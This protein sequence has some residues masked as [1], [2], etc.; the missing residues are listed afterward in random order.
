MESV[1]LTN[2]SDDDDDSNNREARSRPGKTRSHRTRARH[3]GPPGGHEASRARRVIAGRR[4]T[5][6]FHDSA[7]ATRR[8]MGMRETQNP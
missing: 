5:V 4:I 3:H 8:I 7:V 6:R 2:N 1:A